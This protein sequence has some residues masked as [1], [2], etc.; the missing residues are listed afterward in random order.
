[1]RNAGPYVEPGTYQ[2][3]VSTALGRPTHLLADGTW[4][5]ADFAV[6][7]S[8]ARG[9]LVVRFAQGR[10]STLTLVSPSVATALRAPT[11]TVHRLAAAPAR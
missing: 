10:V 3:Q 11:S 2:I 1:M 7:A 8:R 9:T 4:L 6:E 5:Y